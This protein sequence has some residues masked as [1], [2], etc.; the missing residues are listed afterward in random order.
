MEAERRDIEGNILT[1]FD[2][3]FADMG[4]R[5]LG[6]PTTREYNRPSKQQLQQNQA[7]RLL[8]Q[9]KNKLLGIETKV[10]TETKKPRLAGTNNS[11]QVA[12][13]GMFQQIKRRSGKKKRG[14]R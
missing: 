7:R 9:E 13:T 11:T 2:E 6:S 10:E 4:A 3:G 12:T 1:D 14:K 5:E 8:E